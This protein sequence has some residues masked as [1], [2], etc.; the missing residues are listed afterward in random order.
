MINEVNK[1]VEELYTCLPNDRNRFN[2]I[3]SKLKENFLSQP[4]EQK[5]NNNIPYPNT[6]Y[7][8][9]QIT[10]NIIQN[11]I[12]NFNINNNPKNFFGYNLE[13]NSS[14]APTNPISNLQPINL[15]SYKV[16]NKDNIESNN[17]EVGEYIN[18][19]NLN[20]GYQTGNND[21]YSENKIKNDIHANCKYYYPDEYNSQFT[22]IEKNKNF[23][24]KNKPNDNENLYFGSKNN[25][26]NTN[27]DF[28]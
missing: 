3:M 6:G 15:P 16:Q 13:V 11:N 9:S 5:F 19:N 18:L 12:P 21:N 14:L 23:D 24:Y 28:N 10:E 4:N 22:D 2:Q 8:S 27:N 7:N 26:S 1:I 17:E 20:N 25:F